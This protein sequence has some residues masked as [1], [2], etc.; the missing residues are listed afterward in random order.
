MWKEFSHD[1]SCIPQWV[2]FHDAKA[3]TVPSPNRTRAGENPLTKIAQRET[4]K[5]PRLDL[6]ELRAS[7]TVQS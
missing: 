1:A 2:Y 4:E 7:P 6:P 5:L 3:A